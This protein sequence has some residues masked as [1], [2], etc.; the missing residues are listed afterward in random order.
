MPSAIGIDLVDIERIKKLR[1]KFKERF[2]NKHFT[3]TER[4]YSNAKPRPELHYAA[5]YAAKE[6]FVKALGTGLTK[7]IRLKDIGVR[8]ELSGQPI[9][10]VSGKAAEIVRER[11]ITE[12]RTSLT[13]THTQAIAVVVIVFPQDRQIPS[14]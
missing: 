2:E 1:E 6:A 5:R 11:H 14:E 4:D 12:I 10:E 13:H 3:E 7:G 8:N 9:I